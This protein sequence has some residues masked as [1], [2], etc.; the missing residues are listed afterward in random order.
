MINFNFPEISIVDPYKEYTRKE[1]RIARRRIRRWRF[2]HEDSKYK[3]YQVI[4]NI[5]PN[6]FTYLFKLDNSDWFELYVQ[7]VGGEDKIYVRIN[8]HQFLGESLNLGGKEMYMERFWNTFTL[9]DKLMIKPF[10]KLIE[11][12]YSGKTK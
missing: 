11:D 5:G 4:L 2:L 8:Y 12:Y 9:K 7:Y 10:L 6:K 1:K 3:L